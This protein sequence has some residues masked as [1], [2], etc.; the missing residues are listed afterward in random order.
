ML[1][2]YTIYDIAW[3]CQMLFLFLNIEICIWFLWF[4]IQEKVI[5]L[6]KKKRWKYTGKY[7]LFCYAWLNWIL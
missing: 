4:K 6:I 1:L 7:N 5:F 2:F 3:N